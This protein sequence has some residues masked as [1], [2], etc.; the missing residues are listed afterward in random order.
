[1]CVCVCVFMFLYSLFW[2]SGGLSG[3]PEEMPQ[4][5]GSRLEVWNKLVKQWPPLKFGPN[6]LLN[7]PGWSEH[8]LNKE[9]AIMTIEN[10]GWR[11]ERWLEQVQIRTLPN[12]THSGWDVVKMDADVHRDVVKLFE[13]N[14]MCEDTMKPKPRTKQCSTNYNSDNTGDRGPSDTFITGKSWVIQVEHDTKQRIIEVGVV[15]FS[16]LFLKR[17][18]TCFGF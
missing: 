9:K 5:E 12:F 17:R 7:P 3:C 18:Y 15:A 14:H 8:M 2:R 1:M 13:E 16:I 6:E 11:W 10:M 4:D